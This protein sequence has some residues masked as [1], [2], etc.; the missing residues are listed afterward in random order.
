MS[1]RSRYARLGIEVLEDRL[2]PAATLTIS[3]PYSVV[4]GHDGS[5]AVAV[6]VSVTGHT[7]KTI[8]VNYATADGSA[9][10]GSDYTAVAGRLTFARRET[11]KTV[12]V[13]PAGRPLGSPR[14]AAPAR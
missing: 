12:L 14:S 8:S 2:A 10:A 6:T 1:R 3:S 11:T 5:K 9:R 4:E 13:P 7:G